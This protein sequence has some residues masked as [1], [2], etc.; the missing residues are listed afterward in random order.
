MNKEKLPLSVR[1]AMGFT[2]MALLVGG[3]AFFWECARCFA[4]YY[5]LR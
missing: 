2:Y 4:S 1:F 3:I 5:I